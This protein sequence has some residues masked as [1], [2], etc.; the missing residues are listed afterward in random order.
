MEESSSEVVEMALGWSLN[1]DKIKT[2]EDYQ[3][4]GFPDVLPDAGED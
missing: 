1:I 4:A 2:D 3:C